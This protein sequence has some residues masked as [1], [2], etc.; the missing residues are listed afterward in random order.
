MSK[1]KEKKHANVP[2][3]DQDPSLKEKEEMKDAVLDYYCDRKKDAKDLEMSV[4]LVTRMIP[5]LAFID[6]KWN[7]VDSDTFRIHKHAMHRTFYDTV[8]QMLR[9]KKKLQVAIN[10][11][12]R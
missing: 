10:D 1:S 7:T 12:R 3:E 9:D 6:P 2:W 5:N 8:R 4:Q 11:R